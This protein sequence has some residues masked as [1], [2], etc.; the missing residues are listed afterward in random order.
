V[1]QLA[2]GGDVY[3]FVDAASVTPGNGDFFVVNA[4]NYEALPLFDPTLHGRTY[5]L[6][7]SVNGVDSQPFWL[8]VA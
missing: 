2:I 7:L 1:P 4:N 6:R 3:R 8:E 5:P